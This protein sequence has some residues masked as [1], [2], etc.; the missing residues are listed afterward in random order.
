MSLTCMYVQ[1]MYQTH[2]SIHDSSVYN[3]Y[4]LEVKLIDL[5]IIRWDK[6]GPIMMSLYI[7]IVSYHIITPWT[8]SYP[9]CHNPIQNNQ[10]EWPLLFC[11][12]FHLLIFWFFSKKRRS[13]LEGKKT[14]WLDCRFKGKTYSTNYTKYIHNIVMCI[15]VFEPFFHTQRLSVSKNEKKMR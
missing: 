6:V 2:S 11:F 15:N 12:V 10:A 1:Y 8:F 13:T 4:I 14:S 7:C 9:A 3:Y 5:S